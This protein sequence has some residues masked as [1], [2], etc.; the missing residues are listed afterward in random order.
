[1]PLGRHARTI[2]VDIDY[3]HFLPAE[4]RGMFDVGKT[5]NYHVSAIIECRVSKRSKGSFKILVQKDR[6]VKRYDFEGETVKQT[7]EW[8]SYVAR[9]SNTTTD[10]CDWI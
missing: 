1:M 5:V 7:G 8:A 9:R 6:G 10:A 3:I 4:N 2:A